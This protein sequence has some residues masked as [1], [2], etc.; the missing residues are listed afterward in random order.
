MGN[1][2]IKSIFILFCQRVTIR[3]CFGFFRE[4]SNCAGY[5][6]NGNKPYHCKF[7]SIKLFT[8]KKGDET[9][10]QKMYFVTQEH[11]DGE[12]HVLPLKNNT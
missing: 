11:D 9:S 6:N 10:H 7:C 4:K 2:E 1:S 3:F 12:F 5:R 8:E